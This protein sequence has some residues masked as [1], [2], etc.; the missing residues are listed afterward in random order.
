MN[1]LNGSSQEKTRPLS[2]PAEA[3]RMLLDRRRQTYPIRLHFEGQPE[4]T[5]EELE[6]H[7]LLRV[8]FV[9]PPDSL[10]PE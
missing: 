8:I 6:G 5:R 1:S 4:P 2:W 7:R 10:D 3:A 9:D